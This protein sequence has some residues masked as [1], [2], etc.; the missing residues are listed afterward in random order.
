MLMVRTFPRLRQPAYAVRGVPAHDT[1]KLAGIPGVHAALGYAD[2]LTD[3]ARR[4]GVPGDPAGSITAMCHLAYALPDFLTAR[5]R[6]IQPGPGAYVAA[7]LA[8]SQPRRS[9]SLPRARRRCTGCPGHGDRGA[10]G[11]WRHLS[12]PC[13]Q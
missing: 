4:R 8:S 5:T 12:C 10:A 6:A 3:G 11:A 7:S 9:D 1:P 13:D 2:S